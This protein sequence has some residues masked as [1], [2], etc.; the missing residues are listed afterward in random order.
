MQQLLYTQMQEK[1]INTQIANSL[2]TPQKRTTVWVKKSK[3][4]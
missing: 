4:L 2:F 1:E 3:L